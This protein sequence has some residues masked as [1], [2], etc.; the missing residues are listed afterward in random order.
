MSV[1]FRYR[2]LD[3]V[4]QPAER[5]HMALSS[6]RGSEFYLVSVCCCLYTW[7]VTL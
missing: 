1:Y 3:A 6:D 7:A 5:Y 4:F 2:E